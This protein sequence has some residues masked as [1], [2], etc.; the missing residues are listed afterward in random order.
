MARSFTSQDLIQLPRL[1]AAEAVALITE[2]IAA[3]ARA[4][5]RSPLP[6]RIERG[7]TRLE[8]AQTTLSEALLPKAG[9]S[10]PTARRKADI[11]IDA[12]WS[13][14]FDWLSGWCKLGGAPFL[15]RLRKAQQVYGEALNMTPERSRDPAPPDM[16]SR[17]AAAMDALREYV[18]QAASL[19]DPE[20]PG[21]EGLSESLLKPFLD[22]E[23]VRAQQAGG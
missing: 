3:A 17:M 4:A 7:L 12:A 22:W 23:R 9:G 8:E 5:D 11:E 21:S 14:T 6:A 16:R 2:L 20:A 19:A 18:V 1:N 10:D 13:A 15:I